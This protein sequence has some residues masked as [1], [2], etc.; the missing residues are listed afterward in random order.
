MKKTLFTLL[1]LAGMATSAAAQTM[2]A[3]VKN[4]NGYA[5]DDAVVVLKVDDPRW[6]SAAVTLGGKEI[7]SQLDV[8]D[9]GATRELAFTLDLKAGEK[10]TVKI[11]FSET[12]QAADAYPQRVHAQMFLKENG[13]IVPKTVISATENNMY[14]Q[15][16]HHGP[17]IESELAAY[18]I[19][20]DHKQTVDPYGKVVKR[21]ELPATMWYPSDQQLLDKYGDDVLYV[22]GSLG[23]GALK[24]WDGAKATHFEPMA[25]R[26]A[27]ILAMGPVRAIM[28]MNVYGWPYGGRTLDVSSRYTI[29]AGHRDVCV[30]DRIG[31]GDIAGL[32]FVTGVQ[33]LRR[34]DVMHTDDQGMV[35][36]WGRDFPVTDTVKYPM[37]TIGLGVSIP[38]RY[39]VRPTQD[40]VNYLY[41][42]KPDERGRIDYRIVFA[43][44]KEEFGYK[45]P[46]EFFR[47]IDRWAAELPVEVRVK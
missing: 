29:Y 2:T 23:L 34:G 9:E 21:I 16:H 11:R 36:D 17:A 35:A 6:K 38:Q 46:E 26:E 27:K 37:Q 44:E 8:L 25:R 40:A 20:F 3:V 45:T 39:V 10:K 4:P 31:G 14:N 41:V 24:G 13:Q 12:A 1:L 30:Q 43:A 15:L 32:E 28:E 18:R 5:L 33:K 47:Y 19:Y 22:G 42:V 7:P